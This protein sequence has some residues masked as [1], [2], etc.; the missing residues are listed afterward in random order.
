MSGL[1][2]DPL[3]NVRDRRWR[4]TITFIEWGEDTWR[5]E[6]FE[7]TAICGKF[8]ECPV[9]N[10]IAIELAVIGVRHET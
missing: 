5:F 10:V 8:Q 3:H 9:R 2:V 4:I 6:A 1:A 7:F